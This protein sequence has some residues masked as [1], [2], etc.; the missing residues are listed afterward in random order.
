MTTFQVTG[1]S[2]EIDDRDRCIEGLCGPGGRRHWRHN[3]DTIIAMIGQGHFFYALIEGRPVSVV[4]RQRRHSRRD[5]LTTEG[6]GFPPT[7]LLDLP[8]CS[9]I[10]VPAWPRME[11]AFSG[12]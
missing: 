9:R 6:E 10:G 7:R 4:V 12:L 8:G 5:Y 3:V 1:R 11:A 2:L